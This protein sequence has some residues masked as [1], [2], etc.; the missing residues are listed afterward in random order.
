L[1]KRLYILFVTIVQNGGRLLMHLLRKN[2]IGFALGVGMK[3]ALIKNPTNL[4]EQCPQMRRMMM[5]DK[6]LIE[7]AQKRF[8]HAQD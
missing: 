5:K 7:I 4:P 3:T 2:R 8:K 1:A 6:K